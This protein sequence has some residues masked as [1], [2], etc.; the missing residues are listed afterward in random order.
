M[1]ITLSISHQG[2]TSQFKTE[3]GSILIG[4]SREADAVDIDLNNDPRVSRRHARLTWENNKFWL[5]DLGSRH[6]TK[7]NG[8]EIKGTGKHLFEPLGEALIGDTRLR[9]ELHRATVVANLPD[10]TPVEESPDLTVG[11]E[12]GGKS[13]ESERASL[14]QVLEVLSRLPLRLAAE[15]NRQRLCQAAME[16]MA[17]LIPRAQRCALLL[18]DPDR[19]QLS[20]EAY[21]PKTQVPVVS[22]QLANRA[23]SSM[24]GF[25]WPDQTDEHIA[26]YHPT[27]SGMYAPLV[28]NEKAIGVISVDNLARG[29][30][31]TDLDLHLLAVL[32]HYAAMAIAQNTAREA[33]AKQ[34]EFTNRLFSSRFPPNVRNGLMRQAADDS[35]PTGTRQSLVTILNSDIREF[36]NLSKELGARRIGDL[37]NEYFPPLIEAIF[38]YGGTVERFAGDGI[39]AVFGAPE[40]DNRQQEHAVRAALDMQRTVS[41]LNAAR[42]KRKTAISRIGIG[43][44]IGID[45]GEVLNGFIGNAERLEFTVIGDAANF[46]SRYCSSAAPGEILISQSVHSRV[47]KL[48]DSEPRQRIPTKNGL[49]EGYVVKKLK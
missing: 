15:T 36:T 1:E 45:S 25:I 13:R 17:E 24:K 14:E 11:L 27:G 2:Q 22:E 20:L 44:G 37:L 40:S 42:D 7:L 32:A 34:T 5:E 23:I 26:Q 47:W 6:G 43:I 38:A 10:E 31:F 33:L 21:A 3:S 8:T 29:A 16:T 19:D 41:E 46:A 30:P 12:A 39:F 35:L 18:K 9:F 4:R 28:W 48:V 49:I